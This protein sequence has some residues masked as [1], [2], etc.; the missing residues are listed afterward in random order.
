VFVLGGSAALFP[1]VEAALTAAHYVVVRLGGE[2]RFATAVTI[3]HDGLGDP[4][5]LLVADGRGFPDAL[6]AGTAAAKAGGAVLLSNGASPAPATSTYLSRRGG[7]ALI[8]VGGPAAAAYPSGERIVGADRY[9][10][11]QLVASRFFT[12]P[13]TFGLASGTAF[14]DALSGGAGVARSA[15]PILLTAPS[16]LPTIVRQYLGTNATSILGGVLFG[17]DAAVSESPRV[18]AQDAIR[19]LR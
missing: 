18:D 7:L 12:N 14:P 9:D 6:S 10:T 5:T 13:T 1:R 11:S 4:A 3:A 16:G 2:D 8:A 17:G 15:A 19:G